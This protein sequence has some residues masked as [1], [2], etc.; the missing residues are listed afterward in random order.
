M[1]PCR[2]C[3]CSWPCHTEAGLCPWLTYGLWLSSLP[4]PPPHCQGSPG[5]LPEV[6]SSMLSH[7]Q[8][9]KEAP[10]TN[11]SLNPPPEAIAST[12]GV[13]EGLCLLVCK[14]LG[15]VCALRSV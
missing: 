1:P 3:F 9:Q 13:Q 2:C 5:P 14:R 10:A 7:E 8:A 6:Q 12:A 4:L 11:L 15:D